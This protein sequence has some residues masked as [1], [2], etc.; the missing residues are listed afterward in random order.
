MNKNNNEGCK[1]CLE[2]MYNQECIN[3]SK[4][5][6]SCGICLIKGICNTACKEFTIHNS[7]GNT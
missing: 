5:K 4:G 7:R 2:D 1:G 3:K 6:C